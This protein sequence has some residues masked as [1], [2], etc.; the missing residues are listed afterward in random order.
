LTRRCILKFP[1]RVVTTPDEQVNMF[2]N[3]PRSKWVED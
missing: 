2:N 3:T 1:A